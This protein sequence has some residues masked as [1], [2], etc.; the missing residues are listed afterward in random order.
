MPIERSKIHPTVKIWHPELVNIYDS[1]IGEGTKVASFVEIGRSKIGRFCKIEAHVFIAP[2]TV[3]EDYVFVG[4]SASI[5]NDKY[6]DLLKS[7]SEWD[8]QG[9]TVKRGAVI[10]GG[11]VILAGVIVGEEALIGAGAVVTE[12]VPPRSIIYGN[13]KRLTLKKK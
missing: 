7:F 5:Q 2:D 8:K 4:P 13:T 10:G 3:L 6:P 9:V 12:N 1:V 11:A